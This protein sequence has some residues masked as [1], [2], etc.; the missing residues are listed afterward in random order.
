MATTNFFRALGGAVGAAVLGAVFAARAGSHTSA[1]AAVARPDIIDAVQTVFIVATPIA[2]LALVVV[3]ALEEVPLQGRRAHPPQ[4]A[5][6][7][8]PATAVAR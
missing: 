3:L 6:P 5:S 2:A 1:T 7:K 8:P 4:A